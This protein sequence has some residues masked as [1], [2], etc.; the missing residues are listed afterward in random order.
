MIRNGELKSRA[1]KEIIRVLDAREEENEYAKRK[2]LHKFEFIDMEARNSFKAGEVTTAMIKFAYGFN[3]YGLRDTIVNEN[4][5]QAT[6]PRCGAV[7]TWDHVI[8]MRQDHCE[9]SLS[10]NWLQN[11]LGRNQMK[12]MLKR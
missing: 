10:W 4:I 5:F 9:E 2:Y 3:H 8:N 12:Y 1:V 11:S 7:E 6:C